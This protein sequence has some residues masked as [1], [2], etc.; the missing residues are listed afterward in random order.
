MLLLKEYRQINSIIPFIIN[1]FSLKIYHLLALDTKLFPMLG[2]RNIFLARGICLEFSFFS[3]VRRS[4]RR[5]PNRCVIFLHADVFP[6]PRAAIHAIILYTIYNT[7]CKYFTTCSTLS[8]YIL[9]ISH[10]LCLLEQGEMALQGAFQSL[11]FCTAY[12]TVDSRFFK[13]QFQ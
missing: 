13:S 11:F 2:E 3:N 12:R 9:F 7:S 6:A 5:N 1:D 8:L 10:S 4:F